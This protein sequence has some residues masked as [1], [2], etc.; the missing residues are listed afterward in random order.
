MTLVIG[1][2]NAKILAKNVDVSF[3]E[4]SLTGWISL[5]RVRVFVKT[6]SEPFNSKSEY[7]SISTVE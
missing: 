4:Y 7:K 3:S 2:F 1:S 5:D 6:F